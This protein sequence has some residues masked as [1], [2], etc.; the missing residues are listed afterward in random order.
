MFGVEKTFFFFL[1]P[2]VP[3]T[4]LP[5]VYFGGIGQIEELHIIYFK[6]FEIVLKDLDKSFDNSWICCLI[7]EEQNV[8]GDLLVDENCDV[9][10]DKFAVF[11]QSF[12]KL[13]HR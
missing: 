4:I 9:G 11:D 2:S 13:L 3:L 1:S 6:F 10:G 5:H 7:D 8:I 12:I